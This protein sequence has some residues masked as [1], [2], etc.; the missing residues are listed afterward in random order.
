MNS[1]SGAVLSIVL[2]LL[3]TCAF[4]QTTLKKLEPD[5]QSMLKAWE[6]YYNKIPVSG[7]VRVGVMAFETREKIAPASFFVKIPQHT[8]SKLCVEISSRDG[9]YQ[10][11]LPYEIRGLE[12]G[13]Y[14]LNLPTKYRNELKNYTVRD[15][16]IIAKIVK[17]CDQ[18]AECYVLS[19]WNKPSFS[20]QQVYIYLNSEQY[21]ELVLTNP[22]NSTK[23]ILECETIDEPIKTAYNCVC[24]VAGYNL[25]EFSDIRIRR[26]IRKITTRYFDFLDLPI[27][28]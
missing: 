5:T 12:P 13:L 26:T 18:E 22:R 25:N 28:F 1:Y 19:A 15:I 27:R 9:R 24:K 4:S 16:T 8:Q 17:T 3:S 6:V 7:G 23:H 20:S 21:T 2:L 11:K 14:E 10:A